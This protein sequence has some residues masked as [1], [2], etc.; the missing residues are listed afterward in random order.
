MDK[1]EQTFRTLAE[2][3]N[4][5]MI[6]VQDGLI[7]FCNSKII[8]ISGYAEEELIGE[9][10][11]TLVSD[12]YKDL[13]KK[14][15][16]ARLSGE[17]IP[18]VYEI[19]TPTKDGGRVPVELSNSIIEYEGKQAVMAIARDITGRKKVELELKQAKADLEDRVRERTAELKESEDKGR[20]YQNFLDTSNDSMV[21]VD[22]E[23]KITYAN[24]AT[25]EIMGYD[26]NEFVGKKL[27][28]FIRQEDQVEVQSNINKL[29][30]GDPVLPHERIITT[31]H[32]EIIGEFTNTVLW[33]NDKPKGILL[34]GKD[35]TERKEAEKALQES[36]ERYRTL[37]DSATDAILTIDLTGIVTSWNKGAQK[38]LGYTPEEIIGKDCA[39]MVVPDEFREEQQEVAMKVVEVGFVD[40]YETDLI[41]KD[42][43]RVPVEMAV[44]ALVDHEGNTTGL[45]AIIRDITEQKLAELTLK[46]SEERYRSLVE[47]ARDGIY[48]VSF[49]GTLTSL[50]PAFEVITGFPPEEWVGRNFAEI[51]HPEDIQIGLESFH[52]LQSGR[53]SPP[54]ELRVLTKSGEYKVGEFRPTPHIKGGQVVGISGIVRD[55][56]ERKEAEG[57]LKRY[58]DELAASLE[59]K[60]VLLNEIHHR[61]KNNMQVVTSLL[62]LQSKQISNKEDLEVFREGQNRIRSMAQI[63]ERLYQSKDMARV[64]FEDYIEGLTKSLFRSYRIPGSKIELTVDAKD[65]QLGIDKAIPCGLIINELISN[66]LKYAFPEGRKGEI[67]ISLLPKGDDEI[68]L[69]ARDDGVGLPADVD[70]Q[71]SPTLGLHL[72][73]SFVKQLRGTLEIDRTGGTCFRINF[74]GK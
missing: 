16:L 52:M 2:N 6:I 53:E 42:G 37:I 7:K 51:V 9:S 26:E 3:M 13:V 38:M 30:N 25:Y 36:E 35:I 21:I 29:I 18:S 65:V 71:E 56:T 14:R 34:V 27:T 63:H 23:G 28:D 49:D 58:S 11:L 70:I 22:M 55:V 72:V 33:E 24:K 68:E 8:E 67:Q 62:K 19:E 44:S 4:D 12:E 54:H 39:A 15:Y 73:N 1:S 43:V 10:F 74:K 50:N 59:E 48:T 47:S 69:T 17:D 5:G 32:G 31:A 64:D 60:K 40:G 46:E 66:S 57:E 41:A 45:S 61:V 20:I